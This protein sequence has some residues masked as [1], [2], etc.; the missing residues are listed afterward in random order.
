MTAITLVLGY[1]IDLLIGDPKKIP[2]PICFIGNLIS[3]VEKILRA[4]GNNNDKSLRIR[5]MILTI[6]VVIT[7]TTIPLAI[8]MIAHF[9]HPLLRYLIESIMFWQ[10]LATK[11][12]KKESMY[13]YQSL[14]EK[15]QIGK[16]KALEKSRYNLS[17]IVGRDTA[18]LTEEGIIKATVETIAENTSD[19]V[20]A[21]MIYCAL[22]GAPLG[23]AY[24]AINTMDSMLGYQNDK[25]INFGR[26]P[27]K[28]DDIA[29]YL[30]SR[31]CAQMMIFSS[32][33][34]KKN[35]K[36]AHYIWKRDKRKHKS[37]NSAQTESVC[38]GALEIQLA[39]DAIYD[40]KLH[41][42]EYIGDKKRKIEPE[43]IKKANQLMITTSITSI[44]IITL[45]TIIYYYCL[46]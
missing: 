22:G 24:K 19:G 9:I 29:N 36:N 12:L 43:D 37:P 39:G 6:I 23:F 35:A 8:L 45:I 11:S 10:I 42:K 21:P 30:P 41:K 32:L 38:A 34:I 26:Y 13:V 31:I 7:A 14:L 28:L 3:K 20:I 33:L 4:K 17:M 18:Q 40:G 5:G 15:D 1:C 27:A 25:Y 16:Q 46:T 44:T 2:H